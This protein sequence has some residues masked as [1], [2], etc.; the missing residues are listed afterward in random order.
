MKDKSLES[1]M[2]I[3]DAIKQMKTSGKTCLLVKAAGGKPVG[4]ISEH[5]IVTAFAKKGGDVKK[6]KVWSYMTIDVVVAKETDTIDKAL[7][8][9]AANN[10]RHLP[11]LSDGGVVVDVLSVMDLII[12]Q[13]S[14]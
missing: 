5:D 7:K 1:E 11:I 12:K 14:R 4:V 3:D 6:E 9:M 10:I 2:T 13:S 8:L